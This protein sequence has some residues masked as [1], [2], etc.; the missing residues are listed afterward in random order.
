M[1]ID[2]SISNTYWRYPSGDPMWAA[3]EFDTDTSG[4]Y[5]M[6]GDYGPKHIYIIEMVSSD[7]GAQPEYFWI[8]TSETDVCSIESL[9]HPRRSYHRFNIII[10]Q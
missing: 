5:I 3:V 1:E 9:N 4:N 6:R 2:H 7:I 8:D 10:Y